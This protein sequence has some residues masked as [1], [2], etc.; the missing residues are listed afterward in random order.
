[1]HYLKQLWNFEVTADYARS[2]KFLPLLTIIALTGYVF[3]EMLVAPPGAE[4]LTLAE[5]KQYFSPGA[6]ASFL[7]TENTALLIWMILLPFTIGVRIFVSVYGYFIKSEIADRGLFYRNILVYTSSGLMTIL[8]GVLLLLAGGFVYLATGHSFS[9]GFDFIAATETQ[10][11]G[12]IS[13]VIPTLFVAPSKII[14]L[15][16]AL[17]LY[18][19]TGYFLHWLTHV[20]RLL[21]HVVHAPHH[22]PD[23][24]HPIGN[25]LAFTFD[26]VLLIPKVLSGAVLT[27]LFYSQPLV[28]EM[29]IW[30]LLMYNFEIFNH[31]TVHYR[32][33][34]KYAVLRFLTQLFGGHG[35]Y[36]YV[37][38]SSAKEHQMANMGGGLF[39]LWD[40]I[41]GTFAEPPVEPPAIGWT[42][43]PDIYMNPFRVILGGPARIVY[44]LRENKNWKTRLLILFG[45]VNYMP[46]HTTDY[47]RKGG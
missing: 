1:M 39:L 46:P 8:I 40:R 31:A 33:I 6:G 11:T 20:S 13:S 42:N 47:I 34:Q 24:L 14:A 43:N 15:L 44:E 22:L 36:H 32:F 12:S 27:K 41:F 23:F 2:L 7:K 21:W 17:T 18:S 25:P 19:L 29:G 45:P 4:F 10:L 28:L 35:A 26:F 30:S 16:L 5:V 37:H 38:H 3:F 9:Q